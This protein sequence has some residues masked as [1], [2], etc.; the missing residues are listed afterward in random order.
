MSPAPAGRK[1]RRGWAVSRPLRAT[2]ALLAWVAVT[3]ARAEQPAEPSGY[4]FEPYRAPTPATLAGA[5]VVTP[6]EV[7][8]LW[9]DKGAVL[10]DVLPRPPR[11]AALPA[12]TVWRDPPHETLPG[13]TWLPNV[14]FGAIDA[15]TER[16]FL[17]GLAALTRGNRSAPLVIFCLRNCWMSWNAA[18]RA[19]AAGYDRVSWFPDGVDGWTEAGLPVVPAQ[20]WHPPAPEKN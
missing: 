16:Y 14:G 17:D 20:P 7:A 8:A 3:P 4:R 9:R 11:P 5:R 10:V 19:L 2:A 6:A 1:H 13:A 12:D 15:D 18:K